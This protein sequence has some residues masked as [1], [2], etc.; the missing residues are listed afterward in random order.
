MTRLTLLCDEAPAPIVLDLTGTVLLRLTAP[1]VSHSHESKDLPLAHW[2]KLISILLRKCAALFSKTLCYHPAFGEQLSC[3]E[4]F[5][6]SEEVPSAHIH[7][8][9]D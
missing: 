7:T 9:T 6:K 8:F 5:L 1:G 2:P 3:A 4:M